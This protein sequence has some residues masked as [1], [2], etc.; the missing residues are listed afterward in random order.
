MKTFIDFFGNTKFGE[1]RAIS[2]VVCHS[3]FYWLLLEKRNNSFR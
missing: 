2:S 1:Y 3:A